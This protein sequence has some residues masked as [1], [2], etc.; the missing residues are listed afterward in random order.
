MRK[1]EAN[2]KLSNLPKISIKSQ[3]CKKK[4]NKSQYCVIGLADSKMVF[5]TMLNAM[6]VRPTP[7]LHS[8]TIKG[9]S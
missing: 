1:F 4:I 2:K 7:T 9:N 8:C 6:S 5:T 3:Y